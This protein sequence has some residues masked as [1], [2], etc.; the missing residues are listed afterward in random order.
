M[1]ILSKGKSVC[2]A[3]FHLNPLIKKRPNTYIFYSFYIYCDSYQA[4]EGHLSFRYRLHI[5]IYNNCVFFCNITPREDTLL[6]SEIRVCSRITTD[7]KHK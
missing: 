7:L 1:V 6:F 2:W 4:P 3:D 5:D